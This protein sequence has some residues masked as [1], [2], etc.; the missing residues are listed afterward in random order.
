MKNESTKAK[1]KAELDK[2]ALQESKIA[3]KMATTL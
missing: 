3:V 2:L 1:A